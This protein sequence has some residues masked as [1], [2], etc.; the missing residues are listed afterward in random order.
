MKKAESFRGS[1]IQT[2]EETIVPR[3]RFDIKQN[4]SDQ[5][6]RDSI[7]LARKR[8]F[9]VKQ[10]ESARGQTSQTWEEETF[11][12]KRF[13]VKKSTVPTCEEET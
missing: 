8:L 13:A 12:K 7:R 3:K 4:D 9:V 10:E 2:S 6:G 1:T 5:R 11:P